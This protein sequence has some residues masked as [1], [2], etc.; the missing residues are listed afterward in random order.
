MSVFIKGSY[1]IEIH[2]LKI[3]SKLCVSPAIHDAF[4]IV[5]IGEDWGFFIK[6]SSKD[7]LHL[8]YIYFVVVATLQMIKQ[9][10]V[11]KF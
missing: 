7:Y 10:L 4:P 9:L 8:L 5:L 2:S 1:C 11:G 3:Q 6:Q